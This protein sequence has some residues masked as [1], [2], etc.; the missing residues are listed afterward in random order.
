M[1]EYN[2]E[3]SLF[4]ISQG[5]VAQYTGDVGKCTSY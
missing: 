4:W 3:Q 2:V 1:H 5:K